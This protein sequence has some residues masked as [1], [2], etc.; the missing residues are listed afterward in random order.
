MEEWNKWLQLVKNFLKK[1]K[2]EADVSQNQQIVNKMERNKKQQTAKAK[3][4]QI[5]F[6]NKQKIEN[7]NQEKQAGAMESEILMAEEISIPARTEVCTMGK[8]KKQMDGKTVVCE[9]L[10]NG[11]GH[12]RMANSVAPNRE[13]VPIRLINASFSEVTIKRNEKIGM[14]SQCIEET[15]KRTGIISKFDTSNNKWMEEGF[16]MAHIPED[17][18]KELTKV[19][20]KYHHIFKDDDEILTST[21]QVKHS[22]IVEPEAQ[23]VCKAPY[24]IPY[25]QR[26]V[27]KEEIDRLLEAKVIRP[28]SSRWSAPVVL[29]VKKK[30][31]GTEKVRMCI[32]YR[33]LYAV[34]KKEYYPLPNITDLLQGYQA[35]KKILFSVIDV[36]EAYHQVDMEEKDIP[37]TGF[38]TYHGHFE[39]TKMTFGLVNAPA[40]F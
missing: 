35:E 31:D 11:T 16:E 9:P 18:R 22:I 3:Q 4:T 38:S 8:I 17:T 23:P 40:T 27:L 24:R 25:Q 19:I 14:A 36:A 21:T 20:R 13:M 32:D 2:K 33:G 1:T 7:K 10:Q 34:T 37:L 28:S 12:V 6:G 39:Y 26:E 30:P 29:V 15:E 5:A